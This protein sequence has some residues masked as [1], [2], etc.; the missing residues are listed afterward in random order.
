MDIK[1]AK[2]DLTM[3]RLYGIKSRSFCCLRLLFDRKLAW[4]RNGRGVIPSKSINPASR[5]LEMF[6]AAAAV[7]TEVDEIYAKSCR[8]Q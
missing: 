1:R 2:I 4:V 7:L 5:A 8:S 3:V 6:G